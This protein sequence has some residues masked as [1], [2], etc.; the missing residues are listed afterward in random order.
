[1]ANLD[2]D[3]LPQKGEPGQFKNKGASFQVTILKA[4][5]RYGVV[6]V[7]VEPLHGSGSFWITYEKVRI[8][9]DAVT[10]VEAALLS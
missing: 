5:I 3:N 1:M 10:P 6:D 7:L 9:N 4:R 8:M 2:L